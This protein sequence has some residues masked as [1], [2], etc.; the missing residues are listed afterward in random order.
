VGGLPPAPAP[1]PNAQDLATIEA[2]VQSD[3]VSDLPEGGFGLRLIRAAVDELHYE[4]AAPDRE[5]RW[6]LLKRLP[7]PP[8]PPLLSS[9]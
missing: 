6:R 3:L 8:M 4:R 9:T 1:A 7:P 2:S 5:N